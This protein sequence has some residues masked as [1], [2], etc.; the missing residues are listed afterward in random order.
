[1]DLELSWSKKPKFEI[2]FAVP[3]EESKQTSAPRLEVWNNRLVLMRESESAVEAIPIYL[4]TPQDSGLKFSI[5]HD[6]E[7]GY[8]AV[9][10]STGS[11]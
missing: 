5:F 3:T 8:T 1:M 11:Y 10:S 2:Q 4:F 9:H 6:Y 7:S